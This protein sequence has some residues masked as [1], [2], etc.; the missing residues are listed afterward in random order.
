MVCSEDP[1]TIRDIMQDALHLGYNFFCRTVY[2]SSIQKLTVDQILIMYK[3][4]HEIRSFSLK[5]EFTI[6]SKRYIT[7][8]VIIELLR[9]QLPLKTIVSQMVEYIMSTKDSNNLMNILECIEKYIKHGEYWNTVKTLVLRLP[10]AKHIVEK[11]LLEC[12]ENE[13]LN[14]IQDVNSNLINKVS[15]I[16]IS[17]LDKDILE[18]FKSLLA[19]KIAKNSRPTLIFQNFGEN[20]SETIASPDGNTNLSH[21]ESPRYD[22]T[23]ANKIK[24]RETEVNGE[25]YIM[26]PIGNYLFY[27]WLRENV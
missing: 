19:E 17:Q 27:C 24:D 18:R 3:M 8:D 1:K 16:L 20:L 10:P 22:G 4:F 14:D 5:D 2:L 15:P 25:T 21:T 6:T 23:F 7:Q 11:I 9:R 26:R 12:I 13:K